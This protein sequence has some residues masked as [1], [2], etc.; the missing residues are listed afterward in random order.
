MPFILE[1]GVLEFKFGSIENLSPVLALLVREDPALVVLRLNNEDAE[2]RNQNMVYLSRTVCHLERDVAHQMVVRGTKLL[3]Q[4]PGYERLATVL[5]LVFGSV[6]AIAPED[7]TNGI[8]DKDI[9]G[10]SF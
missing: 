6:R 2:S 10:D 4:D 9:E 1:H 3:R 7:E 8:S 5:Q